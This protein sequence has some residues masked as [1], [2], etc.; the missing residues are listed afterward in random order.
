[1]SGWKVTG[2][3][4][5]WNRQIEDTRPETSCTNRSDRFA[6]SQ[7]VGRKPLAANY[8][9]IFT[10]GPRNR[11]AMRI[12]TVARPNDNGFPPPCVHRTAE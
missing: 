3:F 7:V 9:R 2:G 10:H 1:M 8:Q 12:S 4:G 11:E 6:V 5:T